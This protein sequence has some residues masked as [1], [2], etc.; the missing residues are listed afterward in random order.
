VT[1]QATV[2]VTLLKGIALLSHRLCLIYHWRSLYND[3]GL[4]YVHRIL[5][6]RVLLIGILLTLLNRRIS[7]LLR[8]AKG[9]L[10]YGANNQAC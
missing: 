4:W 7:R 9:S 8:L 2:D 5:L 6:S 10:C 3:L 1:V